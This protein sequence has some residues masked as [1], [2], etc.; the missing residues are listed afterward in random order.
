MAHT[1]HAIGCPE[2]TRPEMFMCR[3]HWFS[4]PMGLRRLIW[5]NY[6]TGQCNDWRISKAYAEAAKNCVRFIAEKENREIPEN[7]PELAL[8]DRLS[9]T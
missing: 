3:K 5:K 7:C 4:L 6:R 9:E 1:C 2:L 8:Y